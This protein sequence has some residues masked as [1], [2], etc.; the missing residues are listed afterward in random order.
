MSP[1]HRPVPQAP[2]SGR[3]AAQ[4][5]ACALGLDAGG[6][7][8]RWA[9]A[10]AQSKIVAEGEG[11]ATSGLLL[12]AAAQA[13]LAATLRAIARALPQRP[14]AAL[15]GVT[16]LDASGA[17][18]WAQVLADALA[19]DA[20]AVQACGDIEL[21]CRA[22]FVPAF[23]PAPV[24]TG[25]VC[26]AGTGS[27][28]ARLDADGALQRAGGRGV[29]LD[30]A[31]GGHWIAREALARV[32]RA[33][34]EAPGAWQ[35]SPM[36]KRLFA[37]LGGHDWAATRRFVYGPAG[38]ARGALGTLALAV[39][40]AAGEDAAARQLLDDAGRE[41]ARLV[42]ALLRRSGPQPVALAGRV[43]DLHPAIE[44]SLR[45]AL[46]AGTPVERLRVL[47]HHAAARLAW[48]TAAAPGA[49]R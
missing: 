44:A 14:I 10:D 12:D 13:S 38:A 37:R 22:A 20:T 48:P 26:Y 18:G 4:P 47:P 40:E 42:R 17:A 27:I 3:A 11:P 31:G 34:D 46:P 49:S 30:D 21:L 16:G 5:G 28:A 33:E 36:A 8:T 29:A 15:A 2:G 9:L 19:L 6:T 1:L 39:A 25:I 32:W 7:A 24:G 35:H 23:V 43:W 41:L 45:A